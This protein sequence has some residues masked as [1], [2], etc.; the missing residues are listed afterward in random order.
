MSRKVSKMELNDTQNS[1]FRHQKL[2]LCFQIKYK[3]NKNG[4]FSF[5]VTPRTTDSLG[6]VLVV[7]MFE[8]VSFFF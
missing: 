6:E 1:Y 4:T 8:T 2:L 5:Y 3:L 7:H